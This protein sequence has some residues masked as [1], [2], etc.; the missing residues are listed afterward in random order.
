MREAACR[1]RDAVLQEARSRGRADGA[2]RVQAD[3]ARIRREARS[4]VL[5]AQREVYDELRR[6]AVVAVRTLLEHPEE[7]SRLASA[8][9]ADLGGASVAWAHPDGGLVGQSSDGRR[10][11]ASVEA[12]VEAVLATID[13]QA[14]WVSS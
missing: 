12:L 6:Q 14:L 11:D 9:Q 4:L 1:E 5:A 10:V 13:L 3:R 2:M 8:L 7:R